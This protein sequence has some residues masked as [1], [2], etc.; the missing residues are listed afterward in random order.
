MDR[1]CGTMT[2]P[3]N[4]EEIEVT[5][6]SHLRCEA[7]GEVVLHLRQVTRLR[8]RALAAYR[9]RHHL[10][11]GAEIRRIRQALGL[12]Q[13]ELVAL[14]R[15]GPNTLSRWE[16]GRNVQ[17][18]SMDILLRLLRDVPGTVEYLRATAERSTAAHCQG[19]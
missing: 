18:A 9:E 12:T 10:L 6:Q 15:L 13:V 17:S 5:R 3:V 14:L 7:C 8:E 16:T 11:D 1:R 2:Y 19:D 4:G